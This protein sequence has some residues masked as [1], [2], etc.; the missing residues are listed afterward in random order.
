MEFYRFDKE[1][2]RRISKYDS[3]F[4]M[5]RII[6]T[7]N[8][9]HIGC[10]YLEADGIIGYHEA[11]SPQILLIIAGE[12]E[13]RGEDNEYFKVKAGDAVFWQKDEWHETKTTNGLTGIV[14]ESEDMKPSSFMTGSLNIPR[15]CD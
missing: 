13:V 10:M 3:D 7:A 11:V 8:G 1:T 4:L 14:I 9:A 15:S 6:Q 2:G 12:G 5:S